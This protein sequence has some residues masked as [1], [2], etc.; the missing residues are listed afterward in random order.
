VLFLV[1][2]RQVNATDRRNFLGLMNFGFEFARHP[3]REW[4]KI[5]R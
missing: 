4:I 2:V 3:F 1:A 5:Y